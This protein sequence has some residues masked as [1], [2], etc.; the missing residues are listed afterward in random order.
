MKKREDGYIV[1]EKRKYEH[2][3]VAER[4]LG[5]PLTRH[6]I[7]HHKNGNPSDNRPENLEVMTKAE[8]QVLHMSISRLSDEEIYELI[9]SGYTVKRLEREF[10]IASHHAMRVRRRYGLSAH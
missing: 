2:R 6:D 7:V 8:H 10:R 4:M 3:C 5:R 9:V 1:C